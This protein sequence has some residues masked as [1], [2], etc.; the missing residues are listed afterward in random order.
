MRVA[1]VGAG[2]IGAYVGAMLCRSGCDV[3]LLARGEHG[4]AMQ[5]NGVRVVSGDEEFTVSPLVTD[6]PAEIGPVDVVF[7]GLKAHH[8]AGAAALLEPLME[9]A[10]SVVAAQN[11]IPWWY[12]YGH[13]GDF[14]GRRIESVDPAGAVSAVIAPERAIGCVV[15]CSSEIVAPGVILHVEGKRFSLGEPDRSD[16][17]RAEAFGEAMRAAGFRVPVVADIRQHIWLKLMGN[18][19]LNPMSALTGA[20]LDEICVHPGARESAAMMMREV[21]AVAA[22]LGV[23]PQASVE[24]RLDGAAAVGQHKTSMLQDFEAGKALEL[25]ALVTAVLELGEMTGTPTPCL[26]TLH[27]ILELRV[28]QRDARDGEPAQGGSYVA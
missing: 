5:A 1:V 4:R 13:G 12:F 16:S 3:A 10:T 27:A 21:L 24:R 15:Y 25:D 22:A 11:G 28:A 20:T 7:L 8:Y 23:T 6:D 14:D 2:A 26:Q 18:A 17:A 9:S 19:V